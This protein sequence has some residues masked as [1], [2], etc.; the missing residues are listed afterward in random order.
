[1]KYI[2]ACHCN[3]VKFAFNADIKEVVS[4]DCSLC[5][6]RAALMLSVEKEK[7][8]IVEGHDVL[9]EYRWNT[10][11]AQHF[12]CGKCGIYVFHQ[13]RSDP[14]MHSVNANCVDGLD[15]SSLPVRQVNG[16]SRSTDQQFSS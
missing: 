15:I 8:E 5:S 10:G 11:I 16:K 3:A 4:C 12:F 6:K 9:S 1:M 14:S 13:R 2:G 7:F